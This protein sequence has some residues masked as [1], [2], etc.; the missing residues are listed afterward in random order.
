MGKKWN[1]LSDSLDVA[2]VN[3]IAKLYKISPVTAALLLNR[4]INENKINSFFTPDINDLYDPFLLKDMDKAVKRINTA[5]KN[6]EKIT[7]YGDYDVDGIT[8]VAMLTRYL[9]SKG[10]V[11]TYFIPERE[12]DGYGLNKEALKK[13]KN[14]GTSLIITVD[15]GIS[16]VEEAEFANKIGLEL[17]ITDHH[18]CGE[19]IPQACAVVNPKQSDCL[20]P[21]KELAGAGVCF[22]LVC[23]LEGDSEKI[24]Q[25]YGEYVALA[26]VADVVSLCDENRTLVRFGMKKLMECDIPW[27]DALCSVSGIERENLNSYH[28]GFIVAPRL[29]AAGRMGSAYT[30]LKL[31]LEEDYD[32]AVEIAMILDGEN[33]KRKELG[34]E[35]FEEAEEMI[36]CG[37]YSDQKVIVLAKEGWHSGIIGITASKIANMYEKNVFLLSV[38]DGEA[39]GSGRAVEGL[40]LYDALSEC[41]DCLTKYGGHAMA[42]GLSL[43]VE[44]ID[45]FRKKI[46][47]YADS[48]IEGDIVLSLDID[49]R[50][51]CSGS[52]L[53]LIDEIRLMEP[54]GTG[55]EKPLFAVSGAKIRQVRKTRDGKHMM[56]RFSKGGAEFSSIAFGMGDMADKLYAGEVI[57]IAATLEKN[58]YM[59]NIT[60]QF[61]IIDIEKEG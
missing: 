46:N 20:Y 6:G 16:A 40:N 43:P 59:G 39:K 9:K 44:N 22:K 47:E 30:A 10:A 31:L 28:I 32:S 26:T 4:N 58:E 13:I 54:F 24:M 2:E 50:L 7:V 49:C 19:I 8:S 41:S 15:N 23:A 27:F 36:K 3:R 14:G 48:V 21:F 52:L 34:N 42:A 60:P 51:S 5:V 35:I 38:S 25:N 29:N 61:H 53:K 45:T 17:V 56:L 18:A 12:G 37:D 1:F 11:C 55:N 57:T 33:N